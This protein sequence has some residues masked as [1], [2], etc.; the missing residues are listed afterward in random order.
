MTDSVSLKSIHFHCTN[1]PTCCC[2][3]VC[4]L[5]AK[6]VRF[7]PSW[8]IYYSYILGEFSDNTTYAE[9]IQSLLSLSHTADVL[10]EVEGTK[11]PLHKIIL[12]AASTKTMFVIYLVNWCFEGDYFRAMFSGQMREA[13]NP[14]VPVHD[15]TL[16]LFQDLAKTL[17]SNGYYT[18]YALFL[19]LTDL[20]MTITELITTENALEYFLLANQFIILPVQRYCTLYSNINSKVQFIINIGLVSAFS[21]RTWKL[22]LSLRSTI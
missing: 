7:E 18:L 13:Q 19:L 8:L 22:R 16:A 2:F 14:V 21:R 1:S 15:C 5:A 11:L 6:L 10:V 12:S 3:L 17:Y 9:E 20:S 4:S